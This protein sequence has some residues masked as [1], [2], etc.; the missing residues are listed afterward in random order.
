MLNIARN[1][2]IDHLQLRSSKSTRTN[3]DLQ[4]ASKELESYVYSINTDLVGIKPMLNELSPRH[5]IIMGLHYFKGYT[6][7]EISASLDIPLGSVKTSIRN[8][9]NALRKNFN[10]IDN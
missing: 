1:T 2:A 10:E 3:I 7:P 5:K 8:A 9:I 4:L 6:H